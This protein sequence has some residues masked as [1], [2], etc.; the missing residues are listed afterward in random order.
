[1]RIE[2]RGREGILALA[3][4]AAV[5]FFPHSCPL[6]PLAHTSIWHGACAEPTAHT[7]QLLSCSEVPALGFFSPHHNTAWMTVTWVSCQHF[8]EHASIL[9]NKRA[10][11]GGRREQ[12]ANYKTW[13]Q[14]V[15]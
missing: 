15:D 4:E 11:I 1:M 8:P 10:G 6:L 5:Y 3:G 13:S 14:T 2:G 9:F 7:P 12:S